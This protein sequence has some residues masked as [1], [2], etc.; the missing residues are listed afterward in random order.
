MIGASESKEKSDL[1]KATDDRDLLRSP[2]PLPGNDTSNSTTALLYESGE[3]EQ[4]VRYGYRS[5]DRQWIIPDSR[6][7]DRARPDLW[8]ARVPGQVFV[9]EQH[10][11]VIESGPAIVFSSLVPDLDHFLT[12]HGGGGRVLPMRHPS[13]ETSIPSSLIA[14]LSELLGVEVAAD[15]VL[16]YV[17]A[18]TSHSGFTARFADEL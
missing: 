16:A 1:L 15:D 7:L 4:P 13:G 5:L 10:G 17:A 18:L 9:V 14:A 8:R 6:I 2:R 3:A 11:R 12:K